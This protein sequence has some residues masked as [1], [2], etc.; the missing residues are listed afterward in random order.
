MPTAIQIRG[1]RVSLK[2]MESEV[3]GWHLSKYKN[4]NNSPNKSSL[5]AIKELSENLLLPVQKKFGKVEITYGFTSYQ[6]LKKIQKISPQH[7]APRL[8]QHAS[9]ELNSKGKLICDRGGAACDIFVSGYENNMYIVAKWISENLSFDRMYL[10]GKNRP[11][12]L[13]YG[14]ENSRFIQTMIT[15][16]NGKRYPG[17]R[18]TCKDFSNLVGLVNEL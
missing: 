17:K 12:H 3:I 4:T 7:I 13:S 5:N 10:Y 1:K 8:D 14:P 18:G 6:L 9:C 16:L 15:K 2:R 11:I